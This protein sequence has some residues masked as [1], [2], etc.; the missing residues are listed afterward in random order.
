MRPD[1]G[2]LRGGCAKP[3]ILVQVQV[4]P[5]ILKAASCVDGPRPAR[6]FCVKARR[7]LAAMCTAFLF[8]HSKR[9][10]HVERR[11]LERVF[12]I[13]LCRPSETALGD[14]YAYGADRETRGR[15][16]RIS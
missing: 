10:I 16:V 9:P 6:A 4:W 14:R 2:R 11:I 7:S 12:R 3:L 15:C 1:G 5:P 13:G 8:L